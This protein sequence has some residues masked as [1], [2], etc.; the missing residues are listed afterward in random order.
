MSHERDK[1][2]E[3]FT[4]FEVS[5]A[6]KWYLK[7][8]AKLFHAGEVDEVRITESKIA[9][10]FALL[11]RKQ[12]A[13]DIQLALREQAEKDL[14]VE[15]YYQ[16]T[17][18]IASTLIT[19][20]NYAESKRFIMELD[21]SALSDMNP[22]IFF[23]YWQ[24]KAHFM[25]VEHDLDEARIV[26]EKLMNKAKEIGNEP[27]FYE[28]QVLQAQIEAESGNVLRAYS[29]VDEAF[30]YF[31]S[32]PF[33]RAAFEKK[34]ILSQFVSSPEE[35]LSLIDEYM[36]RYP[37]EGI[38]PIGLESQII[39]FKLRTSMLTP[40]DAIEYSERVL[41]AAQSLELKELEARIRRLLC[42]LYH[43]VGDASKAMEHYQKARDYYQEE[44]LEYEEALTVFVFLPAMLQYSSAKVLGVF[45]FLVPKPTADVKESTIEEDLAFIK[46]VFENKNDQVRA[47]MAHFFELSYKMSMNI[48]MGTEFSETIDAIKDIH[49]WMIEQGE[50]QYSEMI[51]QFLELVRRSRLR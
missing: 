16:Y 15:E 7:A 9:Q 14:R 37:T 3:H 50:I 27:Y 39:E 42:G 51:G 30:K 5:E 26:V 31:Q 19:Y 41:L 24:L 12:E 1:G 34:I 8:R 38:Q 20:G 13:L 4:N 23:R 22:S 48:L 6:L 35:T 18:D 10:C 43:T 46:E 45:N 25:I 28:L 44:G 32:T 29:F 36:Q 17:L 33:E 47:K 2:D 49:E 21:E 11:G 40:E